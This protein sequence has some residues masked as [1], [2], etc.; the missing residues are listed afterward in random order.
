MIFL[1]TMLIGQ[2]AILFAKKLVPYILTSLIRGKDFLYQ[3][4]FYLYDILQLSS[5]T[6]RW[7]KLAS[8]KL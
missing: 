7:C 2:E 4:A 1:T 5:S 6:V 8:G 3:C